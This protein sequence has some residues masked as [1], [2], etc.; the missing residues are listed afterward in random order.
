[1]QQRTQDAD[2][3]HESHAEEVEK[4]NNMVVGNRNRRELAHAEVRF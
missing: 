4:T 2:V 1:L 3:A